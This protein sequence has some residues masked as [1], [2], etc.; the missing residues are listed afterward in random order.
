MKMTAL[1][2][3]ILT[4]FSFASISMIVSRIAKDKISFFNFSH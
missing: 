2:F 4:G 1:L 3:T